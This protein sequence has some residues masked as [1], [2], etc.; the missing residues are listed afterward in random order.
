MSLRLDTEI[1]LQM[2]LLLHQNLWSTLQ[3]GSNII[4]LWTYGKPQEGLE[5]TNTILICRDTLE[6]LYHPEGTFV[7][8]SAALATYHVTQ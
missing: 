5:I 2:V 3:E 7:S 4:L 1:M 6:L 8:Y